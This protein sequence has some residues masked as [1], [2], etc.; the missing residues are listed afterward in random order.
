MSIDV[1]VNH[2]AELVENYRQHLRH[3]A[4]R[5]VQGNSD[6]NGKRFVRVTLPRI[7]HATIF[8]G[9]GEQQVRFEWV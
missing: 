5:L 7:T 6:R 2:E 8:V 1:T 3:E 4:R 9:D